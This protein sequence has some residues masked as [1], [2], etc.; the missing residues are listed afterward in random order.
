MN[1]RRRPGY[2]PRMC[3]VCRQTSGTHREPV[4][5]ERGE[6]VVFH[7]HYD[8]ADRMCRMSGHAAALAAVTFTAQQVA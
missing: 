2:Q 4:A 1:G 6:V 7:V 5:D 3:P 8:G